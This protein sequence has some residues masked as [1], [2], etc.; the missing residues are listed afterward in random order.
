MKG[1]EGKRKAGTFFHVKCKEMEEGLPFI[2][3]GVLESFFVSLRF[4]AASWLQLRH[5][6][7]VQ[8]CETV[9]GEHPGSFPCPPEEI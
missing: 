2:S 7:A 1:R 4:L 5:A 3:D 8:D 9:H 6:D